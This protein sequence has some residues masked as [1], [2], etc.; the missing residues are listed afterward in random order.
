MKSYLIPCFCLILLRL[1]DQHLELKLSP[2]GG[3]IAGKES[4]D[5]T[6]SPRPARSSIP[7][8]PTNAWPSIQCSQSLTAEED[9]RS[10]RQETL[11]LDHKSPLLNL[12]PLSSPMPGSAKNH[13]ADHVDP[14]K[15]A[16]S[17]PLSG[18]KRELMESVSNGHQ[19]KRRPGIKMAGKEVIDWTKSPDRSSMSNTP[20]YACT[21]NQE[22]SLL[23][24]GN[25]QGRV[26]LDANISPLVG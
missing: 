20:T 16:E 21:S 11:Q 18:K 5:L 15:L 6:G 25:R 19:D 17:S 7:N 12:F 1:T 10:L 9:G 4:I 22:S 24:D 8:T 13:I 14:E 2:P 23:A 26:E 3:E